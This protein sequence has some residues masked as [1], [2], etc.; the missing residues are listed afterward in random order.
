VIDSAHL[1]TLDNL[2]QINALDCVQDKGSNGLNNE[3]EMIQHF[4]VCC[5]VTNQKIKSVVRLLVW[6]LNKF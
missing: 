5:S 1:S 6:H 2:T 3:T 4:E